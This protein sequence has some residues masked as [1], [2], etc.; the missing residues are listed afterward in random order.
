MNR[1]HFTTNTSC[2]AAAVDQLAGGTAQDYADHVVQTVE[3]MSEAYTYFNDNDTDTKCTK[4]QLIANISNTMSDR[5]AANQAAL[6]KVSA[7]WGKGFNELN[8]HLH[9]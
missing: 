5:C 9:P 8:C 3:R 1:I 4:E 2:V 7:S 6:S